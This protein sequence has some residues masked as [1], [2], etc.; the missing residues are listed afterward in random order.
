ML[1][2]AVFAL[3]IWTHNHCC[4]ILSLKPPYKLL[5]KLFILYYNIQSL[6]YNHVC[7]FYLWVPICVHGEFQEYPL[8]AMHVNIRRHPWALS[9]SSTLLETGPCHYSV[10]RARCP[11]IVGDSPISAPYFTVGVLG[12]QMCTTVSFSGGGWVSGDTNSGLDV[13]FYSECF[14]D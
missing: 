10:C 5:L 9:S 1:H 3:S 6:I 8:H 2:L 4:V 12:S 7:L 11:W 13:C 14:T